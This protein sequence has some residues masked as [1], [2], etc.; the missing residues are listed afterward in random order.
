MRKLP[1]NS[2]YVICYPRL[3][4]PVAWRTASGAGYII[5]EA[6]VGQHRWTVR[7]NNFPDEPLHTLLIDGDEIVHF[8]GW[9]WFW[10]QPALPEKTYE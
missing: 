9:P 5:F 8:N 6:S 2:G 10:R 4:R 7:L 1:F 3:W